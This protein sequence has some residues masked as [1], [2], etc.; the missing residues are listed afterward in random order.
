MREY[1]LKLEKVAVS[2][3]LPLEYPSYHPAVVLRKPTIFQQNQ[4][5][6]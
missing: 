4:L 3:V 6:E 1:S 2:A 5:L